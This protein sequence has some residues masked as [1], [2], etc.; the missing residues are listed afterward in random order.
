MVVGLVAK[1]F[2]PV[3]DGVIGDFLLSTG[4]DDILFGVYCATSGQFAWAAYW[5]QKK[6]GMLMACI[7]AVAL[8]LVKG[9]AQFVKEG[10]AGRFEKAQKT[11]SHEESFCLA[12]TARDVAFSVWKAIA[13]FI[14]VTSIW[15]RRR[16]L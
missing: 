8:G 6:S 16:A 1:Y 7:S 11:L 5:E 14:A 15:A 4:F 12:A 2:I 9:V 3:V 10:T 13:P